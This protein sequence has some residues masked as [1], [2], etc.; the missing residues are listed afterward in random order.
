MFR[1]QD[2]ILLLV[3]FSSMALGVFL[4][5]LAGPLTY[6]PMSLVMFLLF[7][8]FLSVDLRRILAPALSAPFGTALLLLGRTV[9][10]PVAG[11][12]LFHL[13][14]PKYE[15]A[16]LVMA[17]ASTA[18]LAPFFSSLLKADVLLTA[19]IVILSSLLLPFTLP[20]LVAALSGQTLSVSLLPM[21]SMLAMMI[22]VPALA[23]QACTR[24]L[25]G[26]ADW[27]V[28]RNFPLALIAIGVTNVGVFSRYSGY[29]LQSPALALEALLAGSLL[30]VAIMLVG[31]WPFRRME[32]AFRATALV[33]TVF[34]NYI[35]I[36]AFSSQFFGPTE[37]TFAATYS[38]PFFLQ[39][40]PLR[41]LLGRQGL[42]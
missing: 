1:K 33:C 13:I 40:L 39:L 7:L 42:T 18:V 17:G 10:L 26:L 22:F 37:A 34:P 19:A 16:A 23:G 38:I 9:L 21:M 8:S 15:L 3:S 28:G 6:A 27:L 25:P 2:A 5:R 41:R 35:L 12:F 20:P 29:F 36:L 14:W 24:W 32:P 11:F 30:V 4:P 31:P